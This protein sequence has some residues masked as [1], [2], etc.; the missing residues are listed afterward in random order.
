MLVV[1]DVVSER[2]IKENRFLADESK[3]TS[4][5][6]DIEI[7]DVMTVDGDMSFMRVVKSLEELEDS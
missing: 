2:V 5:I 4:Q 3:L 7:F 6:V 1:L